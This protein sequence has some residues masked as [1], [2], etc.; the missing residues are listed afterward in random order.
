VYN[1]SRALG[2]PRVN[3]DGKDLILSLESK[4]VEDEENME[5]GRLKVKGKKLYVKCQDKLIQ[6]QSWR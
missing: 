6:V 3:F 4:Y 5:V 1:V 2:N